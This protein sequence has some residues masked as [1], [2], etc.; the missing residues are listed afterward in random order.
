MPGAQLSPGFGATQMSDQAG[1]ENVFDT[2]GKPP[3]VSVMITPASLAGPIPS[4]RTMA[5]HNRTEA[6]S[7]VRPGATVE[8]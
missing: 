1:V 4:H 7:S 3:A 6:C 5:S 2:S 8:L